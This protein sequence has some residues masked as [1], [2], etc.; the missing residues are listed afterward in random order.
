MWLFFGQ[1]RA[2]TPLI[3]V[4]PKYQCRIFPPSTQSTH[5]DN[6]FYRV[7]KRESSV[8]VDLTDRELANELASKS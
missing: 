2:L 8:G 7:I 3:A 5:N 4:S 6:T 1:R